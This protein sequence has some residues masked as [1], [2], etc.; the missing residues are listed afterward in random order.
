MTEQEMTAIVEPCRDAIAQGI[1][2]ERGEE[3]AIQ[4]TA[5][6]AIIRQAVEAGYRLGLRDGKGNGS[7]LWKKRGD[8]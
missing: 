5:W 2:D 4:T 3:F 8:S 7:W 1:A 6:D